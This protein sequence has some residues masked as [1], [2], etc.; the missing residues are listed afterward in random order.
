VI[1]AGQTLASSIFAVAAARSP[2]TTEA[3]DAAP[4][5]VVP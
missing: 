1:A 5:A 4:A 3:P 2:R